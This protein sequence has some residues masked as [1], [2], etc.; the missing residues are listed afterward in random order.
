MRRYVAARAPE[1]TGGNGFD[2]RGARVGGAGR[3]ARAEY[4]VSP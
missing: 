3:A 2:Q 4:G 1:M